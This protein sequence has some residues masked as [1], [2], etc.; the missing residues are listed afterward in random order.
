MNY[1]S[2]LFTLLVCISLL[3]MM[4]FSADYANA[5]VTLYHPSA[6]DGG[7]FQPPTTSTSPSS[8]VWTRWHPN[9]YALA[10]DGQALWIGGA[11]SIVR[12]D[13]SSKT[14]QRY[15][16]VDGLPHQNVYAV[17]VDTVGNRWFG[18]DGGL[19]RLDANNVWTHFTTTNSGLHSDL[20]DGL[21]I[22]ADNTLWVSHG[23]PAGSISRLDPDG[24]WR[25]Y[26]SRAVAVVTDYVRIKQTQN[27]NP[28]WSVA[29]NEI[30]VGYAVYNGS[31]H[32]SK[33]DCRPQEHRD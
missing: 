22:G 3:L 23:L 13:K 21:A 14:Y 4:P 17:A 28:L 9:Q 11:G 26:P 29:G 20:V 31:Q 16:A 19:S 6:V 18:G 5:A 10:D 24:T 12:W 33:R 8:P 25:W 7:A 1:L 30:W 15:T 32:P 2:K 27:V